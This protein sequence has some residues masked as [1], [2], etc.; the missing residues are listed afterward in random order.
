MTQT[1]A[2]LSARTTH[3]Q[4]LAV[5]AE[6]PLRSDGSRLM[7]LSASS[8]G[9]FWRC[10]ERWRRRYLARER[11]PMTG[12]MLVGR[13][14]GA[15]ATAH[16]AA[17]IRGETLS[18][19]DCDDLL[20]VEFDDALL[21]PN[22]DL[23]GDDPAALREQARIALDAYLEELAAA[24]DPVAVERKVELR[25]D[26]AGWSVV[27]YLDIEDRADLP[28]D[29]KVGAKHVTQARADADPQATLY[30]LAR[31]LEGRPAPEFVFHSV[32]RGEIKSGSRCQPVRTERTAGQLA[33]FERRLALTARAVV[34]CE[35]TGDWPHSSPEGWWCS[36][37][38]CSFW[39][40]C[41]A[42]GAR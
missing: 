3:A 9:L 2:A 20:V 14:V 38:M 19:A 12:R 10:P 6:L 28:I 7:Q 32:R 37:A 5:P 24:V 34:R 30:L 41:E 21:G 42:G 11:E 36:R 8:V 15:A 25:F 29:L 4:P 18:I 39:R 31:A 27:G 17:R 40:S 26:G 1:Q 13:A 23:E 35:E 22:V 16:F 33:A